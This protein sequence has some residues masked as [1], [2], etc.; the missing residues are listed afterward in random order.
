MRDVRNISVGWAV[1]YF[2]CLLALSSVPGGQF[3]DGPQIP[4]LDKVAHLCLYA[5]LGVLLNRAGIG[6]VLA[7]FCG[8]VLGGLDEW[9]QMAVPGRSSEWGD[10]LA[11]TAG[12][13]LGWL[14]GEV[15]RY[16]FRAKP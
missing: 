4:G 14:V 10:W 12:V 16:I 8:M 2:L 13:A 7:V 9:W 3:P 11:D 15:S 5:V 6:P 1:G